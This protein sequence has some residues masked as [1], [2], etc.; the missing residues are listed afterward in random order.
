MMLFK[1]LAIILFVVVSSVSAFS[2]CAMCKAVVE[3]DAGMSKGINDGILYLMA[4]PYILLVVIGYFVYKH[5]KKT[6]TDV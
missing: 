2:Q 4:V 1:L 3:S 6:R 5:Y